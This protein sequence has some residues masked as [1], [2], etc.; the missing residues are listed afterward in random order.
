MR[1]HLG[2]QQ[3]EGLEEIFLGQRAAV[4]VEDGPI[5]VAGLHE[6]RQAV[7]DL[8]G[9]THDKGPLAAQRVEISRGQARR[10][11]SRGKYGLE[12]PGKQLTPNPVDLIAVP[13]A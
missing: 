2:G 3:V 10:I 7:Q 1:E 9:S 4:D 8:L 5:E 12:P 6:P 11:H 13:G